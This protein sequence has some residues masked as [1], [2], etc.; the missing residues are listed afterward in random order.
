MEGKSTPIG[1]RPEIDGLRAVAVLSVIFYHAGLPGFSGGYVGV[2]IFFVISGF[3]ITSII[4]REIAA[5]SFTFAKFYE[6]RIRR[7][8][9]ALFFVTATSTFLAWFILSPGQLKD[10]GQSLVAT[11]GFAANIYFFLTSG[12]FSPDVETLPMI[13]MWSLAV[14][15]QFYLLFP[16]LL[17]V[18]WKIGR[19][20]IH[21]ILPI[22]FMGSL[23]LCIWNESRDPVA[24]FY[25]AHYRAWELMIGSIIAL[26]ASRIDHW[27]AHR[28]A[29]RQSCQLAGLILIAGG[30]ALLDSDTPFP[31]KYAI[32]PVFGTALLI[33]SIAAAGPARWLLSLRP[34]VLVGLISYSAYLWHQPLFAFMR[35]Y[36]GHL[37]SPIVKAAIILVALGAAWLSWRFVEQPFRDRKFLKRAQIFVFA[38]AGTGVIALVGLAFHLA[39]GVPARFDAR[40]RALAS[41]MEVSPMRNKCHTDGLNYRKPETACVYPA[42]R[43]SWALFGDS[44]AIEIGQALAERLGPKGEG[45]VHLTF[46]GCPPALTFD[47][48]NPGCAAWTREASDWLMAR[49]DVNNVLLVYRHNFYLLG[50]QTQVYPGL[51]G[52]HANFLPNAS[53]KEAEA[54]YAR[55]FST[56]VDKFLAAGKKVYIL[57]PIPELPVHVERF[58][59]SHDP[60]MIEQPIS[61]EWNRKRGAQARSILAQQAGK[62]GVTVLDPMDGLCE[63]TSCRMVANGKTLY[64]DDNHP[65]MYGARLI[66]NGAINSGKLPL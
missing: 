61:L 39:N 16:V 18:L 3:L 23:S 59:F 12:Y 5:G 35:V 54:A 55:G 20:V 50:D 56:L 42:K 43:A 25:L 37:L 63:K 53:A 19:D 28:H 24:N 10:F 60:K 7:I 15:E 58:I 32:A 62:P 45:V 4:S 14:E 17:I 6:R 29:T 8:L 48:Q 27:F 52:K 1:Y 26:R 30:I 38:V 36:S 64:F 65:S 31:G 46:S 51:G 21:W 34:M 22:L 57:A 41:T 47:S 13:H 44:H 33:A 9:P 66:V 2:D 11:M 40:T 49:K